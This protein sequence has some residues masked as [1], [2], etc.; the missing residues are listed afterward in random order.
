M[1]TKSRP[2]FTLIEVLVVVAIIA[3]LVAVLL[4]S[5]S[6]AREQSL[7]VVC[8]TR[9]KELYNG[10]AFYG[11]DHKQ[12]F[13]HW[14]SWLWN[15]IHSAQL[16]GVSVPPVADTDFPGRLRKGQIY[17]YI[18]NK[19]SYFCPKDSKRRTGGALGGNIGTAIHSYSRHFEAHYFA[20]WQKTGKSLSGGTWNAY[21]AHPDSVDLMTP[22]MIR[23]GTMAK[24][25][26]LH[27]GVPCT[28]TPDRV[29]LMFE[30]W[31]TADDIVQTSS[32]DM[33]YSDLN[34]GYSAPLTSASDHI[35]T[36]HRNRGHILYWDGH[37]GLVDGKKLN[38]YPN[39]YDNGNVPAN[40]RY[41]AVVI[42]G[43]SKD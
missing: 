37:I 14:D 31:Q 19:E 23:P 35:T 41:A 7:A 2:A 25:A 39:H 24:A 21:L 1:R 4:P 22:D 17:K 9:L 13:P 33:G 11:A 6:A 28:T 5:L 20:L 29:G 26:A 10:H 15:G 43:A 12:R 32:G 16:Q 3:L 30:E 42:I 36:R 38:M 34:D 27:E 18:K 40:Q 8:K